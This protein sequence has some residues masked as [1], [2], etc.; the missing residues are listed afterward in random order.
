VLE[1]FLKL[2]C[3]ELL[4]KPWRDLATVDR[5]RSVF[6]F[7]LESWGSH[8][9]DN[10]EKIKA[11]EGV[12]IKRKKFTISFKQTQNVTHL[13]FYCILLYYF[14]PKLMTFNNNNSI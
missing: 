12:A 11:M 9:R 6:R 13:G 2:C 7:G 14:V 3:V 10:L 1:V 5:A 4:K 8:P